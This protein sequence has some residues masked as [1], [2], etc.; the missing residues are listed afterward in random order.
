MAFDERCC[1]DQDMAINDQVTYEI[2][3]S[4]I[5]GEILRRNR[6]CYGIKRKGLRYRCGEE[7]KDPV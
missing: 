6:I 5:N 2:L 3:K 7:V 1:S 4:E